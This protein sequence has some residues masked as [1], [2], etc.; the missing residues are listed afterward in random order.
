MQHELLSYMGETLLHI[1][2]AE[3]Q[4][5]FCI[6]YFFPDDKSKTIGEIEAQAEADRKKTLGQLLFL[7]RKR[8]EVNKMFDK[9]LEQ[10]VDDRNALAHGFLRI[11]GVNITS[12]EGIRNGAKFLEGLRAQ[13]IYV[14][15]TMRGLMNTIL[16]EK[17][18]S[19]E[20]ADYMK[21]AKLIFFG[22]K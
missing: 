3:R 10:F 11:E 4:L 5:Q 22:G 14:Q 20:D 6:S 17:P 12:V 19:E 15:K 8:I 1:Q 13:A 2:A 7:M 9:E 18:V 16:D 21:L